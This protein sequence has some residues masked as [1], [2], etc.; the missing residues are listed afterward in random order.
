MPT[1]GK[2][3][4]IVD[5][6]NF[7]L[8]IY[9]SSFKAEGFDVVAASDGQEAW[10]IIQSGNVPDVVF[11]G[12]L[13]PRM[14]G[15]DL[16]R[17]MQADPKLAPIPVAISSHRGREEDKKTSKELNVD[18][19]LIQGFVPVVEVVRRVEYLLGVYKVYRIKLNRT[20]EDTEALID[21]LNKQ[22]QTSLGYMGGGD[23]YLVFTPKKET[24]EFNVELTDKKTT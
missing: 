6:D 5:D 3:I 13:M 8:Q 15:F 9:A 18:D 20:E 11:T 16:I 7:L 4:L 10:D 17:K 23:L 14:T 1:L 19:F 21:L 12:I 2:K 22:Q 24:G